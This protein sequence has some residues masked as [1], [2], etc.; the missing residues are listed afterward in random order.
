MPIQNKKRFPDAPGNWVFFRFTD[1]KGTELLKTATVQ[2]NENCSTCHKSGATDQIFT[3]HYPVLRAAQG[4]G[5][6]G[7]G[8]R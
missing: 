3:Q 7:I 8:G 1:E 5:E 6:A 4:K 2:A